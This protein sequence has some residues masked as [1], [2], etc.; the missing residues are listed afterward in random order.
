MSDKNITRT[1]ISGHESLWFVK[2]SQRK[3]GMRIMDG[4]SEFQLLRY[5][6]CL[7]MADAD[8]LIGRSTATLRNWASRK[9]E[10]ETPTL[11]LLRRIARNRP[12]PPP[13]PPHP[14]CQSTPP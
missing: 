6:A 8:A 11:E 10:P 9:T 1:L 4:F 5:A 14:P 2:L 7:N 12:P 3:R 13:P